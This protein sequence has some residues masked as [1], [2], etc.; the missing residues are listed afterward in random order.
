MLGSLLGS[1]NKE[2]VLVYL[3][4]RQRG[5]ARE[6]ARFFDVPLYPVQRA[7]ESLEAAGV[8]CSRLV[9]KT[10]EFEWNLGYPAHDELAN[11]VQRALSLY[12]RE[13][14]DKLRLVRTRPRRKGKPL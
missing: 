6:V 11:L 14:R 12:P 7:M 1:M 10:R 8:I 4:S 2:R 9:G 3:A 13:L 5:Y